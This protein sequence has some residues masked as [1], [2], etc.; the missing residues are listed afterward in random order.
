MSKGP[1]TVILKLTGIVIKN[2]PINLM[3]NML[4]RQKLDAN[5]M[6]ILEDRFKR[7]VSDNSEPFDI[8][9][10]KIFLQELIEIEPELQSFK[11]YLKST[12]EY[13]DKIATKSPIQLR[14]ETQSITDSNPL[15]KMMPGIP[16]LIELENQIRTREQALITTLA[17]LIYNKDKE[18]YPSSLSEL[19]S[20]GYIKELPIDPYSNETLVYRRTQEGFTLYSFG[21]DYDDDG[22]EHSNWG[23]GEKG[24]DQVFWPVEKNP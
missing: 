3:F 22:G 15:I 13:Y 11:P 23:K 18:R 14:N 21:E 9:G 4:D 24:G 16:R 8:R 10:E 2:I 17:I 7:L 5:S 12:L 6:K 19:I 1:K 20:A